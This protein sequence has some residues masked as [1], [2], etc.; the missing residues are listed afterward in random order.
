[1]LFFPAGSALRVEDGEKSLPALDLPAGT[2][3]KSAALVAGG[4]LA[5]GSH[6]HEGGGSELLLLA[7]DGAQGREIA[8]PEPRAGRLRAEPVWL[9]ARG[10][11]V[12][13]LWLE[14]DARRSL[15]LRFAPFDGV[16]FGPPVT[17]APPA[18]G[19]QLALAAT[20]LADGSFLAVWSA[21]DGAD[22]EILWSR[23]ADGRWSEPALLGADNGVPDITPAVASLG[24]GAIAAWNRY[25]PEL[26]AYR[27][28]TSRL[29]GGSWSEP[30]AGPPGALYP[31][32]EILDGTLY[33]VHL[34]ATPPRGWGFLRLTADGR[35]A[36]GGSVATPHAERPL[37]VP[38]RDPGGL[39]LRWD[40]EQLAPAWSMEP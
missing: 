17:V 8:P 30:V 15:A 18:A 31:S 22:D 33:L 6:P 28:V 24:D 39:A 26:A 7:G 4:W 36:G 25:D 21:F 9:A 23:L 16:G 1:M 19:S 10:H 35:P 12:G 20:P 34:R 32:F 11:G 38:S 27:L 40:G 14:G 29:E 37:L 2:R 3:L 5:A 13:L